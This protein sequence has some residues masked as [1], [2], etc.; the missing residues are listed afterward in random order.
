MAASAD[1]SVRRH[2]G[3]MNVHA[4]PNCKLD[5]KAIKISPKIFVTGFLNL[6]LQLL[7]P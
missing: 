7:K 3:T 2:P 5:F 1:D 6:K 4:T